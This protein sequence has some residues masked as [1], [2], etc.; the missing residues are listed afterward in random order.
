ME[1]QDVLAWVD[2]LQD[3]EDGFL[4]FTGELRAQNGH[5]LLAEV[6][7]GHHVG[8]QPRDVL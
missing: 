7:G 4:H 8:R 3:F 1:G 6:E 2:V 5:L